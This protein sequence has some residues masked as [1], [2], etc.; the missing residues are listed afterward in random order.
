MPICPFCHFER[1]DS[2]SRSQLPCK[3]SATDALCKA[4][5][6]VVAIDAKIE[7][8]RQNLMDM[9]E[10]RLRLLSEVN[11]AHDQLSERFPVEIISNIFQHCLSDLDTLSDSTNARLAGVPLRLSQVSRRW[12]T[13]AHSTPQLWAIL[14]L[15]IKESQEPS[16]QAI[17][18]AVREWLSRSGESN[19]LAIILDINSKID[20]RTERSLPI[21]TTLKNYAGRVRHFHIKAAAP[22]LRHLCQLGSKMSTLRI[23]YVKERWTR[24]RP[25]YHL[26]TGCGTLEPEHF[27]IDGTAWTNF[28]ISLS[29]LTHLEARQMLF[30]HMF[31]ILRDAPHLVSCN[32]ACP[33][34]HREPL[35]PPEPLVKSTMRHLYLH[36]HMHTNS[37]VFVLAVFIFPSL[38]SLGL[39]SSIVYPIPLTDVINHIRRSGSQLEELFLHGLSPDDLM[40]PSSLAELIGPVTGRSLRYLDVAGNQGWDKMEV[41]LQV[42]SIVET[43]SAYLSNLRTLRLYATVRGW[44]HVLQKLLS[45]SSTITSVSEQPLSAMLCFKTLPTPIHEETRDHELDAIY[46]DNS[47]LTATELRD[48]MSTMKHHL[49][50][51]S[52][53]YH[54]GPWPSYCSEDLANA[55]DITEEVLVTLGR[56]L[57]DSRRKQCELK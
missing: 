9:Q 33:M 48:M 11:H 50:K 57:H 2:V 24:V 44:P 4:C 12:R 1:S 5:T 27:Y 37:S 46:D 39:E 36:D 45:T 55:T 16:L 20:L 47:P 26:D 34:D 40:R 13:I 6:S 10:E 22:V 52:M 8:A 25:Y 21:F 31:T 3:T 29:R 49:I 53:S 18:D 23:S 14:P 41:C 51:V 35:H 19:P 32:L 54:P 56:L 38:Q 30:S 7:Q 15:Y 42:A 43:A 17:H 28:H